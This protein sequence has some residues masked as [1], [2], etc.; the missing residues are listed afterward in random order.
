MA[1]SFLFQK[2]C[3]TFLQAQK[4]NNSYLP[5]LKRRRFLRMT[6]LAGGSAITAMTIPHLQAAWSQNSP[7]IAIIG[8]GIA[9]LNAAYQL[10]KVGLIATVYEAKPRVGGRIHSVT[11]A[12]GT[13][14][15]TELGGS[16]INRNHDDLLALV[17]E[18]ELNLFNRKQALEKMPFPAEGYYFEGKL[19]SETEV[20]E[21]LRPL[22][23]QIAVDAALLEENFEKYALA[24]DHLSVTQYLDQHADKI[25]EPFIRVL[26]EN[27]IRTEYGVE[28]DRSSALQLIYNLPTVE[29]EEV[30]ILGASDETYEVEGGNSK[31]IDALAEALG[32]QIQTKKNL[33]K[34][35]AQANGYQLTFQDISVVEADYVIIA[36]PFTVLRHIKLEVE[37]P[38]TLQEF[39]GQ[40]DLGRNEKVFAGFR[41]RVWLQPQGFTET[42]WSDLGFS[43][44]W[45]ATQRQTEQPTSALTFFVGG[46]EVAAIASQTLSSLGKTFLQRFEQII[47]QAITTATG[48]FFRTSWHRD[49]F[50]RGSYTNF[51]PGQYSK[52]SSFMYVESE[53]PEERQDVVVDNLV[54]AGEHLSDEFY[55][56]MNGAA[57]TGRLA[58]E[59]V[60][61]KISLQK[62][63]KP[64]FGIR[65]GQVVS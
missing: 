57:Q 7:K 56:F 15:I 55:G 48:K 62:G 9:G 52:F 24:I 10:K 42:V 4:L 39:I 32:E 64:E 45:E 14:L 20:A 40:V 46:K 21:K 61:Q 38:T 51:Q 47:P 50:V 36:I 3:C 60:A 54:F 6:A 53:N 63:T 17:E 43:Q 58:A 44:V 11:G 34:I 59:V 49:S 33:V 5:K 13:G 29:E 37:L 16:F 65:K 35:K 23:R 28:P 8:G 22:A 27:T 1:H 41:K 25:S 26:I 19:H 12:V 2:F 18:F 30:T 31:I